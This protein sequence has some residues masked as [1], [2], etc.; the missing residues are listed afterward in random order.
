MNIL[1]WNINK[2]D[3]S[4]QIK[5]IAEFKSIDILILCEY[6]MNDVAFLNNLNKNISTFKI[7]NCIG[8]D[9]IKIYT[10]F[11][12]SQLKIINESARWTIR[13]I[14]HPFYSPFLLVCTHLPSKINWDS[15][16]QLMEATIFRDAIEN[17]KK[18]TGVSRTVIIGDLNM[19]PFEDGVT[20]TLALHA[21]PVKS[22]AL[23]GK[24]R[25]QKKDYEYYYNPMW[26]FLGDESMGDVAGTHYYRSSQHVSLDWNIF[27]QVIISPNMI[28]FVPNKQLEI[29]T[30]TLKHNFITANGKINDKYSDHLPLKLFI[31]PDKL[32]TN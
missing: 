14:T 27:D 12:L 15:S 4:E 30:K 31:K 23:S 7:S 6:R 32:T 19:N 18:I 28:N 13:Q 17:A 21:T 2:K 9:K 25:V 5:D 3:L 22:I 26:N 10:K 1:F 24:R 11:S 8:C 29:I 20:S 16:S